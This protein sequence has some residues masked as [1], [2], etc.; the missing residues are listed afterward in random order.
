MATLQ[1]SNGSYRVLFCYGD[2]RHSFTLGKVD[3]REAEFAAANVERILLRIDQGLLAVPP[4]DDIV[5]FIRRDGRPGPAD[6]A[7]ANFAGDD[8]RATSR[9]LPRDPRER[10]DRTEYARDRPDPPR[11]HRGDPGREIR[12]SEPR[13]HRPPATRRP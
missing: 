3:R 5:G 13:D 12:A 6:P 7:P 1:L 10:C 8:A 9:A 2:R 11:P 4:H